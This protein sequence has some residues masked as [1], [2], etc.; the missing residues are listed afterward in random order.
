MAPSR[1]LVEPEVA[2]TTGKP[3]RHYEMK[4]LT[5]ALRRFLKGNETCPAGRPSKT[6]ISPPRAPARRSQQ[7]AD[8][9]AEN[10]GSAD[11]LAALAESYGRRLKA[12]EVISR[13]ARVPPK[14]WLR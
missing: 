5:T 10:R 11:R 7:G 2:I 12:A 4:A 14:R 8:G 13:G 1:L 3:A 9:G 6:T